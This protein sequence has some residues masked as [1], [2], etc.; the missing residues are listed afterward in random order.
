MIIKKKRPK[1]PV[2]LKRRKGK[3]KTIIGLCYFEGVAYSK[4][5]VLCINHAKH[6][7]DGIRWVP[8]GEQC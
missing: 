1:R 7:C 6:R 4:G 3:R 2:A 8:T 5:D